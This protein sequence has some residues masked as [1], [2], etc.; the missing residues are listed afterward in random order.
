VA[1]ALAREPDGDSDKDGKRNAADECPLALCKES[2]GS[3]ETHRVDLEAGQ[4]ELLKPIRFDDGATAPSSRSDQTFDELAATLRANPGMKVQLAAH[5][6]A[7]AGVEA[8]LVLT[9]KRAA[10]A[11]S[12]LAKRG[13]APAR[14][15]A[16]GCG[17]GRPIAPNNVP[18][19]RKKNERVEIR[20][21][22]PAPSSGVDSL[23]GCS[24]SE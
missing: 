18:W 17:E 20:V 15:Q 13:I 6:A 23:Q 11:R 22:D 24:A 4:I 14:I 12:E 8:S 16:Y 19:G 9:R 10:A 21:L 3:P 7:E 5:V 1:A 2:N